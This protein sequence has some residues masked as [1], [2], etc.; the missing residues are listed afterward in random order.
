[1]QHPDQSLRFHF[2]TREGGT[3][4]PQNMLVF[5]EPVTEDEIAAIQN[6]KKDEIRAIEE[7]LFSQRTTSLEEH[8]EDAEPFDSESEIDGAEPDNE[9]EASLAQKSSLPTSRQS[10]AANVEFLDTILGMDLKGAMTSAPDKAAAEEPAAKPP[11]PD[12]KVNYTP[13]APAPEKP[14]LAWRLHIRNI[15]NGLPV[16]R[17][18]RL[19]GADTW[20]L[21]YSLDPLSD[22][23]ARR[24]YNMCKNRRRAV[25]AA[26]QDADVAANFYIQNLVKMSAQ[27]SEWRQ[28]QDELDAQKERVVLY[29]D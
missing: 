28:H 12:S 8:E 23:E 9:S 21:Q 19:G 18:E 27:G 16:V 24:Q 29:N 17:P 20:G 7:R 26:P 6:S 2:E 15:V 13:T 5:A 22:A 4:S 11:D 14:L 10:N 25:L 1:M 3:K